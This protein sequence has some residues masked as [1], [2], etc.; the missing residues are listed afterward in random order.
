METP[1]SFRDVQ[2]F[3]IESLS[4]AGLSIEFWDVSAVLLPESG[5]QFIRDPGHVVVRTFRERGEVEENLRGLASSDLLISLVGTNSSQ[6][7]SHR[8][9]QQAW[10]AS[11]ARLAAVSASRT[12]GASVVQSTASSRLRRFAAEV[13]RDLLNGRSKCSR[14]FRAYMRKRYA[15]RALDFAWVGSRRHELSQVL[16]GEK[17]QISVLHSLDYDLVLQ[18]KARGAAQRRV[19]VLLDTMGPSHPDFVTFGTS[20]WSVGSDEYFKSLCVS[21]AMLEASLGMR[22]EIAAH[23]R[24]APESLDPF[25]L[26]HR[27]RYGDTARAVAESSFVVAANATTSL[28]IAVA[29]DKPLLLLCDPD[30]PSLVKQGITKFADMTNAQVWKITDPPPRTVG[31]LAK[32]DREHFLREFVKDPACPDRPF[33][34]MVADEITGRRSSDYD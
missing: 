32:A 15:L 13:L 24:A 9:V 33:W 25:Y 20:Y 34:E 4:E 14:V 21:L 5:R 28:G 12:L 23:P 2:R 17:T 19:G 7:R 27:V 16:I 29:L 31:A 10:S 18:Q 6:W 8:W 22:I 1:P 30:W 26:G 3:G 11:Q